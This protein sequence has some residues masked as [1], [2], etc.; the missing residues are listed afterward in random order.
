M[1]HEIRNL[2]LLGKKR[3]R[4]RHEAVRQENNLFYAGSDRVDTAEKA[5]R[6]RH[7]EAKIMWDTSMSVA[8][9]KGLKSFGIKK[10]TYRNAPA[11][12]STGEELLAI[13]LKEAGIGFT[14]QFRFCLARRW[15]A[16][17]ALND[18]MTL[19]EVEGGVWIN[20][21]HNRGKRFEEDCLKYAE[22]AIMGWK[23]LRFS[24]GQ[25]KNGTALEM[26]KRLIKHG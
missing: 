20:G 19:I 16:D 3:S 1:R 2:P 23:V 14:R 6:R 10:R 11:P 9:Y 18:S 26:I 22:A 17:F 25:V 13:Q 8:E 21:A 12:L 15:K 4:P 7:E 5:Q 24:T